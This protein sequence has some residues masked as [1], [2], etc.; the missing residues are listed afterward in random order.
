MFWGVTAPTNLKWCYEKDAAGSFGE[1]R[2]WVDQLE[3]NEVA[4]ITA[5]EALDIATPSSFSAF[6][7]GA[8][9]PGDTAST[10]FWFGQSNVERDASDALQSARLIDTQSS[11][12]ETQVTGPGS[13]QFYW[14]ISSQ[15]GSDYLKLYENDVEQ[16]SISGEVNWEAY[17]HVIESSGTRTLKWCY[18]KDASGEGGSDTGW[19]D[20]LLY[21]ADDASE[22]LDITGISSISNL[23]T[24]TGSSAW[25]SQKTRYESSV[26]SNDDAL[27]SAAITD[28]QSACFAFTLNVMANTWSQVQFYWKLS[29]EPNSDYLKFYVDDDEQLSI[30]GER[31][32]EGRSHSLY[33]TNSAATSYVLKWCYEKDG[34]GSGA[35]DRAW[36]DAFSIVTS[37]AAISLQEALDVVSSQTV[38]I[39]AAGSNA[40]FAQTENSLSQDGDDTM[41]SGVVGDNEQSC[42]ETQVTGPQR[43]QFYWRVSSQPDADYLRFYEYDSA[44]PPANPI[45]VYEISGDLP[46]W[47][48]MDY[49]IPVSGT[50]TLKWCYEKNAAWSLGDDRAWVDNLRFSA[51]PSLEEAL[52][53]AGGSTATTPA[54]TPLGN[55]AW[56]G[57]AQVIRDASDALQSGTIGDG[58][59]S[60]FETSVSG[61]DIYFLEFY[62]KVDSE[63]GA[64][65][66]KLYVNNVVVREISGD[67]DW[68]Q[69]SSVLEPRPP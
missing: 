29:S 41:Q 52:D 54:S 9:K 19:V 26:S 49:T 13:L 32:W 6:M 63:T 31:E 5:Q 17:E 39:G 59:S 38:D 43:M 55:R 67:V 28:G 61:D 44:S 34:G 48:E 36:V 4:D 47:R 58:E 45:P 18:E 27:Q 14:K 21:S 7:N 24:P 56:F 2:A 50:R 57:Q 16:K 69:V 35:M 15:L 40:W 22:A 25:F 20:A 10:I 51:P 23:T 1:D 66:L 65:Y 30:S 12:F 33:N 60:C 64:D 42:F 46:S 53:L 8:P 62:W 37:G 11:C 3:I 68:S